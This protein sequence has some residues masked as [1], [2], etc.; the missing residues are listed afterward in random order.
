MAGESPMRVEEEMG[1]TVWS[2]YVESCRLLLAEKGKSLE[3]LSKEGHDLCYQI[4][5]LGD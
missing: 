3:V 5:R 2:E 4:I 1:E